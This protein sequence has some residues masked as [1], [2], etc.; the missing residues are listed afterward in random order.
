M[1][2]MGGHA[3]PRRLRSAPRAMPRP[4]PG[5]AV[6]MPPAEQAPANQAAAPSRAPD[7]PVP[8]RVL[9]VR[10]G[11][12]GD[13]VNALTV[14]AAVKD[15]APTTETGWLVHPLSAPLVENN[16]AV[17]RV[18]RLPRKGWWSAWKALRAEVRGLGYDCVVDLQRMLK[19]AYL[20]RS[21]GAPRLVGYDRARSKEGAWLFYKERIP[22][23]PRYA[24]M[25]DQYAQFSALLTGSNHVRHPLPNL[26]S[27]ALRWAERWQA[28]DLAPIVVHIGASKPE[29]RWKP[30]RYAE[31]VGGLLERSGRAVI[32]TGGPG[33]R[34]DAAPTLAAHGAHPSFTGLVGDT[35]LYQLMAL[36]RQTRLWIGCDT[37]PMHLA[38]ALGVPVVALFGPADPRRTG[39]Y[40]PAHRVLRGGKCWD[41]SPADLSRAIAP[42][43]MDQVSSSHTLE[44]ALESLDDESFQDP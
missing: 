26:P 8:R 34:D 36:Y 1:L 5:S 4:K 43:S 31:L 11:A 15:A 44:V 19:S 22:R 16:P 24:H 9:F 14:A 27:A 32:L 2:G 13:V 39:P 38:A 3:A 12:I 18:H 25:V 30:A 23:G 20:A 35:D 21:S 6:P 10:L 40:G 42:A 7:R 17:D 33:D 41:G 29:N 37:G 28:P